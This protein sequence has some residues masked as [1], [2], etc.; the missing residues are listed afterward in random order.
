MKNTG[1][2]VSALSEYLKKCRW[3]G[4]KARK[5]KRVKVVESFTIGKNPSD[6]Q[7]LF[8]NVEY[9]Q[10]D[11]ETY[12]LPL[13]FVPTDK[14]EKIIQISRK[15]PAAVIARAEYNG[16]KGIFYDAVYNEKFRENLFLMIADKSAVKGKNGLLAGSAGKSFKNFKSK[17]SE[18]LKAEHSNTGILYG[19]K[20][21]L[22][23][24]RHLDKGLNP[25]PEILKFLTEETRYRNSPVFTG[26][27][28]YRKSGSASMSVGMMHIFVF[29]KGDAW[30]Y[31]LDS[32]EKYFKKALLRKKQAR[33][34]LKL[35]SVRELTGDVYPKMVAILGRRTAELHLALS[36]GSKNPAF[37]PESFTENYRQSVFQSMHQ[38]T[39]K[40]FNFLRENPPA[41]L[42]KETAEILD[43]EKEIMGRYTIF[44]KKKLAVTRIRI[45]G[46]YHL[47]QVL[48]TGN[49]FIILDFEGEPARSMDERR[50]KWSP[51][52]DI[53]GMVRSFHYAAYH[54]LLKSR[55]FTKKDVSVLEP[56]ADL[57]YDNISKIFLKSYLGTVKNASFIPD[58]KKDFDAMLN[59]FL[60]E[61][62]V[63]ELGYELNNR[64]EWACIPIKAIKQLTAEKSRLC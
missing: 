16:Q 56:Y 29:G 60:L 4:G 3:F 32:V 37:L 43:R 64:P 42:K 63:Y 23:L 41:G 5:I 27:I 31:T 13:G 30:T 1:V 28:E 22:K 49:D 39:E 2:P 24:Y 45:H 59:V 46:D 58:D 6:S 62:A 36:S 61:K 40:V 44:T 54:S 25:D 35:S 26:S 53:A 21:F 50:M 55:S 10:G 12:L 20:F 57:W 33:P 17:K 14:S 38:L 52:K 19:G 9:T 34:E 47:G 48:Y 15:N 8:L 18:V 51:I 11:P 7:L